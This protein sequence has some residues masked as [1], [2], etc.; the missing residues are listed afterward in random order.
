MRHRRHK[1]RL[2]CRKNGERV[3]G[4]PGKPYIPYAPCCDPAAR[5]VEDVSLGWGKFCFVPL[6]VPPTPS[7]TTSP[8]V[9]LQCYETGKEVLSLAKSGEYMKL[10]CCDENAVLVSYGKYQSCRILDEEPGSPHSSP[11]PSPGG[12]TISSPEPSSEPTP[13]PLPSAS[14]S[15]Q[16]SSPEPSAEGT[17]DATP[18]ES[19]APVPTSTPNPSPAESPQATPVP[20]PTATPSPGESPQASPEES[21]APTP[22]ASPIDSADPCRG[23]RSVRKEVRDMTDDEM[24]AYEVRSRSTNFLLLAFTC[25]R[26]VARTTIHADKLNLCISFGSLFFWSEK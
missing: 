14:A 8:V 20:T 22:S 18:A 2:P 3:V 15:P 12:P 19:S 6:P 7:A 11:H 5:H 1:Y 10:A 17:P 26:Q 23:L 24:K 21:F 13:N 9:Q 25:A 4:A 16:V